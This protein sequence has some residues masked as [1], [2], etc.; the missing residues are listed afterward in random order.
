M[1]DNDAEDLF[2]R[3]T[4]SEPVV[5]QERAPEPW[6]KP[7]KHWIR[8]EQWGVLVENFVKDKRLALDGRPFRYL[9]LPGRYL[10][11]IRVLHT[12][13]E[14]HGVNLRFLGFDSSRRSDS[15]L[16][17]SMDEVRH[18]SNIDKFS[19][20]IPDKFEA[21]AQPRSMAYKAA[22]EFNGFDAINL[23]LCG[24]V[25]DQE[26]GASNSVLTALGA[27]IEL[28][29]NRRTE[30]WL[31][32]LT[33]RADQGTVV[34][35]VMKK[36][37]DVL[38]ENIQKHAAFRDQISSLNAFDL[39]AFPVVGSR[40]PL[41]DD[42]GFVR[43]F[44]IGFAKWILKLSWEGWDVDMTKNAYYRVSR[45]VPDMLSLAFQFNRKK[46]SLEDSTGITGAL[47][48]KQKRKDSQVAAVSADERYERL[49]N[50]FIGKMVNAVDIDEK[51]Y[52]EEDLRERIIE[53]NAKLLSMARFDYEEMITWGREVCWK[54]T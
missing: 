43:A 42:L 14:K 35:S 10:L 1:Q 52:N 7:R 18:L 8:Q 48:E 21:I 40:V 11:D 22:E 47:P 39:S 15:E 31:L 2:P 27:I 9:T 44:G 54:P 19:K 12:I 41:S 30:P 20:V 6:H 13:C 4:I 46:I 36:L 26:A 25:A 53:A 28:Q 50:R 17:L 3:D 5:H 34:P 51:L 45:E 49:A 33:T 32:F 23:D 37:L 29:T 38:H 24:S 16:D